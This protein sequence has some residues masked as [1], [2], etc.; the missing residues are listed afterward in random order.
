MLRDLG[1]RFD[2]LKM[3]GGDWFASAGTPSTAGVSPAPRTTE[4][5]GQ[6]T[7]AAVR[8]LENAGVLVTGVQPYDRTRGGS[9]LMDFVRGGGR[10]PKDRPV[11]LFEE[12][13]V[14]KYYS[15]AA[16]PVTADTSALNEALVA[17]RA[18]VAA[19]R[20]DLERTR[21]DLDTARTRLDTIGSAATDVATLRQQLEETKR[22]SAEALA[23]RDREI[24]T[25]RSSMERDLTDLRTL[26]T[27]FD[28]FR[29][30]RPS[31]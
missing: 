29:R 16:A 15:V 10:I 28:A 26:R 6:R 27:E 4:V 19:T 30:T 5:V 23:V 25:L 3:L 2:V 1:S 8:N 14:V 13:G 11:T 12:N 21:V 17:T 24:A 22:T 20:A 9:N 18:D 31:G 7:D